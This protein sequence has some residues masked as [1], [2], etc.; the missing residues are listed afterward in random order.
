M[1]SLN[2]ER[3]QY[4]RLV[5]GDRRVVVIAWAAVVLENACESAENTAHR[6]PITAYLLPPLLPDVREHCKK[7][8]SFHGIL[9]GTLIRSTVS[10]SLATEE[11]SLAGDHFLE[12]GDVFIVHIGWSWAALGCT[13]PTTVFPTLSHSLAGHFVSRIPLKVIVLRD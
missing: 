13:E 1:L 4:C 10:A 11:A 2:G 3:I 9:N 5:E 8:R 6:L 12:E 7:S